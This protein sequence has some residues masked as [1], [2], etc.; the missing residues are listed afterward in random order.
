MIKEQFSCSK[1]V[2][3]I[4]ATETINSNTTTYG[5]WIDTQNYRSLTV[6]IDAD[7]TTDG[8]IDS[9]GFQ[10]SAVVGHGDAADIPEAENLYYPGSFPI[11]ADA[12]IH[13]GCVAKERW[14]RLK[15]VTTGFSSGNIVIPKT[16][17]LLQ[18]S[19]IKPQVKESSVVAD[20]D[21]IMPSS[22][23]DAVTTPPKRTA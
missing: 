22:T 10:E 1:P 14:V 17:G 11:V 19:V 18:D 8:Q 13:V 4:A 7:W 3:A 21:M 9:I 6:P 12:L 5:A 2:L 20:A 23:A 16:A 15:I